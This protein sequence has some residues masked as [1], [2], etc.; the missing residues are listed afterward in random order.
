MR[1][2]APAILVTFYMLFSV[3]Q[4]LSQEFSYKHYSIPEGLVQTQVRCMFQDSRGYIWVGT[5]GGVS[6]FDGQRFANFTRSNGLASNFI[7]QI[8]EDKQGNICLLT[9]AGVS[10]IARNDRIKNYPFNF[11]NIN[12]YYLYITHENEIMLVC[13]FKDGLSFCLVKLVEGKFTIVSDTITTSSKVANSSRPVMK[14]FQFD[15]STNRLFFSD[16]NEALYYYQSNKVSKFS[17][18]RMDPVSIR[19]C[20]DNHIYIADSNA[21]FRVENGK[22]HF[23]CNTYRLIN[24]SYRAFDINVQGDVFFGNDESRNYLISNKKEFYDGRVFESGSQVMFDKENNLWVGN[25]AEG[26]FLIDNKAFVNFIP[27]NCDV[28]PYIF[29]IAEDKKH[30]LWFNSF[31]KGLSEYDGKKFK[32]ITSYQSLTKINNF[33]PGNLLTTDGTFLIAHCQGLMKVDKE[34]FEW[35]FK[36]VGRYV[37]FKTI[38]DTKKNRIICAADSRFLIMEKNGKEISV[39][40]KPGNKQNTSIVS[41]SIDPLGR[42]WLGSFAGISIYDEGRIIHLPTPEYPYDGGAT[43]QYWDQNKRLWVGSETGLY[44]LENKRVTPIAPEIFPAWVNAITGLDNDHLLLG[45]I[46]GLG[47][48]DL[49]HF[50]ETGE[51]LIQQ[52]NNENGYEGVEVNQNGIFKDSRGYFW[53]INADRVVRMDPTALEPNKIPP[54]V[55][56]NKIYGFRDDMKKHVLLDQW[57]QDTAVT[58]SWHE[59]KLLFEFNA[60]SYTARAQIRYQFQLVGYDKKWSV[61][62]PENTATYTNLSPGHYTFR[63]KAI[64]C[65]GIPCTEAAVIHIF[66]K[67]AF[68]QTWWFYTSIILFLF[69]STVLLTSNFNKRRRNKKQQELEKEKAMIDL[70]LKTIRNQIDPHFTFNAMNSIGAVI[71]KEDKQKA[72][73]FFTRF[74]SLIRAVL[75][76]SDKTERSLHEEIEFVTNYL[77]L[78]KL[79]FKEKFSYKIEIEPDI[80]PGLRIPKLI[81]QAYVE[82]AIKHGLMHRESDGLLSIRLSKKPGL[83]LI[84]VNDNGVGRTASKEYNKNN[85]ASTGKGLR[86]MDE[87]YELF[88]KLYHVKIRAEVTDLFG[89]KGEAAGTKVS[90]FIPIF[91]S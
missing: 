35:F 36:N 27:K 89:E 51:V 65:S 34:R 14:L 44:L 82:N 64:N 56:I 62:G 31:S 4:A 70:Q 17:S 58:Y 19:L 72:Y 33:H 66:I 61:S 41:V 3:F 30:N 28:P 46:N 55:I 54:P 88:E 78:E 85:P 12:S 69:V 16:G 80:D 81:I 42:Y 29:S 74:S 48:L 8:D 2:T 9:R 39:P 53:I 71:Y 86:I 26:L 43:C 52:Y 10:L 21:I 13:L 45:A 87:Y 77:E 6:R 37:P 22:Y 76:S 20:A 67:P 15:P 50:N 79:R 25:D 23:I 59:N 57:T 73:R 49:K 47:I 7:I 83:V 90:I 32:Q 1:K 40:V 18:E 91:S 75:E 63:V 84:E 68:W 24:N 60:L 5:K 11:Q 38:E